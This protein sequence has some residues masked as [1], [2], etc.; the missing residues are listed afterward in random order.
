M[1]VV[2]RYV[3]HPN[4]KSKNATSRPTAS[5]DTTPPLGPP[6]VPP[7]RTPATTHDTPSSLHPY[8]NAL[9][10]LIASLTLD[11]SPRSWQFGAVVVA[12]TVVVGMLLRRLTSTG[13]A[14]SFVVVATLFL[15]AS[16]LGWRLLARVV[17]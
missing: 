14:P 12:A 10:D 16:M 3:T 9:H 15:A 17:A 2:T 8:D 5:G 7:I 1:Y 11:A 4:K 6:F 13:T